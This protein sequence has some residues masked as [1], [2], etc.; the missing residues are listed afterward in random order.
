[1]KDKF[2][3]HVY[4]DCNLRKDDFA[5]TWE[6]ELEYDL[7]HGLDPKTKEPIYDNLFIRVTDWS[8]FEHSF[9]SAKVK[10]YYPVAFWR[11]DSENNMFEIGQTDIIKLNCSSTHVIHSDV[12][13]KV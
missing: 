13:Y 8:N 2:K 11:H 6:G 10:N 9:N 12:T 1:M 3:V 7:V 4:K 5:F